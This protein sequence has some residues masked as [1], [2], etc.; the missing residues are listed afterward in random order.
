MLPGHPPEN[1]EGGQ[2]SAS[3]SDIFLSRSYCIFPGNASESRGVP[4]SRHQIIPDAV[5]LRNTAVKRKAIS[6][7]GT[8]KRRK[9]DQQ[10]KGADFVARILSINGSKKLAAKFSQLSGRPP[11]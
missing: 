11:E 10:W 5:G 7:I 6:E 9:S 8:A 1:R 2:L 3:V 4:T